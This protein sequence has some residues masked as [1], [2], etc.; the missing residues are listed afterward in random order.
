MSL[1]ER[2]L[3]NRD[4]RENLFSLLAPLRDGVVQVRVKIT[5]SASRRFQRERKLQRA[6]N[7]LYLV[8]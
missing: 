4:F 3:D 8:I 2:I 1:A 5:S 7:E 6:R